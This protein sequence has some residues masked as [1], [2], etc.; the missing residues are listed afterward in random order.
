MFLSLSV[1]IVIQFPVYVL[2]ELGGWDES[3]FN[4]SR[5]DNAF[6]SMSYSP[7]AENMLD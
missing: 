1:D 5:Q 6:P 2:G 4:C 3:H 7:E